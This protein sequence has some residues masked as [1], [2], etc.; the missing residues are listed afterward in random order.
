MNEKLK[1]IGAAAHAMAQR[2]V[3]MA[4]VKFGIATPEKPATSAVPPQTAPDVKSMWSRAAAKINRQREPDISDGEAPAKSNA[5]VAWRQ[6]IAK[7][8][9][10]RR[11]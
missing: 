4:A 11:D 2:H 9:A 3:A 5:N 1:M 6:A 7:F 10:S 8:N